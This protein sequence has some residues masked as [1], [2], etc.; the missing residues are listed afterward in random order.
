MMRVDGFDRTKTKC[1]PAGETSKLLCGFAVTNPVAGNSDFREVTAS[2]GCV[3]IVAA[4]IVGCAVD[5]AL[6]VLR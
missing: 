3:A 6:V 4:M 5:P 2:A 1:L